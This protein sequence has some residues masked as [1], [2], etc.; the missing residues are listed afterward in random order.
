[1]PDLSKLELIS[2]ENWK[3]KK[4]DSSYHRVLEHGIEVYVKNSRGKVYVLL[5]GDEEYLVIQNHDI[6]SQQCYLTNFYSKYI[7]YLEEEIAKLKLKKGPR[8]YFYTFLIALAKQIFT[9]ISAHKVVYLN[10]NLSTSAIHSQKFENDLPKILMYMAKKFPDSMLVIQGL[11]DY[12]NKQLLDELAS[13]GCM[14][15]LNRRMF[16]L[17]TSD[18]EF[19]PSGDLSKDRKRWIK[20]SGNLVWKELGNHQ[21]DQALDLYRQLYMGHFSRLSP[22]Y[23]KEFVLDEM[24]SKRSIFYGLN[25]G[26]ELKVVYAILANYQQVAA[27]LLGFEPKENIKKNYYRNAGFHLY[28]YA[29]ERGLIYNMSSGAVI[30]KK[31]RG[32]EECYKYDSFYVAHLPLRIRLG[33]KIVSWLSLKVIK[34]YMLKND[35]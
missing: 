5:N 11:N 2:S 35:L 20:Q 23:T 13:L 24:S 15:V 14:N 26:D 33:M 3:Q 8:Y 1:M 6:D 17:D 7:G 9:L 12:A 25:E 29:K 31:R 18:K 30:Y 21:I 16:I 32:A 27:N 28:E 10:T 19:K 22:D 4:P 34:Q